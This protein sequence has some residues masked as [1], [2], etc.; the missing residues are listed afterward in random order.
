MI[1]AV[2]EYVEVNCDAIVMYISTLA[3]HVHDVVTDWSYALAG[4]LVSTLS[5]PQ[6]ILAIFHIAN[7]FLVGFPFLFSTVVL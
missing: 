6:A 2:M 4:F 3:V 1:S 7:V 5:V